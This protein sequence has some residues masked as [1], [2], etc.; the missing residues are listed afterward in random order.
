MGPRGVLSDDADVVPGDEPAEIRD[1][2]AASA[3]RSGNRF[4]GRRQAAEGI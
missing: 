1:A 3:D 2:A 4:L